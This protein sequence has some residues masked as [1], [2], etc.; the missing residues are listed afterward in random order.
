MIGGA[1]IPPI[2][3]GCAGAGC[4]GAGIAAKFC[5]GTIVYVTG[6]ALIIKFSSSGTEKLGSLPANPIKLLILALSLGSLNLAIEAIWPKQV[7]NPL[8]SA[9][10]FSTGW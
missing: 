6:D 3:A 9:G 2:G 1:A 5:L 7:M 8:F 10:E 4:A